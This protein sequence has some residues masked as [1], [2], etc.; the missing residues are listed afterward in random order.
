MLLQKKKFIENRLYALVTALSKTT[1]KTKD[2][3][4]KIDAVRVMSL[5]SEISERC[6]ELYDIYHIRGAKDKDLTPVQEDI[7]N[8]DGSIFCAGC[9]KTVSSDHHECPGLPPKKDGDQ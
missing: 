1:D 8:Y 7:E 6:D 2:T 3:I 5:A 4:K 9:M